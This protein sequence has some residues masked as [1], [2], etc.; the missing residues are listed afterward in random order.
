METNAKQDEIARK[1][2]IRLKEYRES[3][4]KESD[5]VSISIAGSPTIQDQADSVL[6]YQLFLSIDDKFS[7]I[8]DPIPS[9][10][11]QDQ[12]QTIFTISSPSNTEDK[13]QGW[14]AF[15]SF[16]T[17]RQ[18]SPE[19]VLDYLVDK[20]LHRYRFDET[21]SGCRYWCDK[22]LECLEAE[23]ILAE[24][25]AASFETYIEQLGK[26]L[27][28]EARYPVPVRKGSFY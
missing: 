2:I 18:V 24:G 28:Q 17:L 7:V 26:N 11:D 13:R 21:F 10:T 1:F 20:G 14:V 3:P 22:A 6:H 15:R 12:R 8:I 9:A 27:N 16:D 5:I 19:Q 23:G 25:S 4:Q